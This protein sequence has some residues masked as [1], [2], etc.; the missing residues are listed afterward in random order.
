MS[1]FKIGLEENTTG[2]SRERHTFLFCYL[3]CQYF[4]IIH[5]YISICNFIRLY[6]AGG[7]II[8]TLDI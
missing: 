1:T 2:Y 3:I 6:T 8:D 4:I 5:L 7:Q